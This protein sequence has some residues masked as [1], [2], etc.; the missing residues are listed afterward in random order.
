[1][2]LPLHFNPRPY[3]VEAL[4]AL[5]S[6]VAMCVLCWARRAGKDMT[7]FAYASKKMVEEPMNVVLV[8]PE[9][10]QGKTA[11]WENVEN[12]GWKTIDRIP[13]SLVARVDNSDMRITL[14]NGST[15]Q[16]LGAGDPEALRGANGKIY[17]FS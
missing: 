8:F 15:F 3:Q 16:V 10:Q 11:F 9:K 2:Q 13:K 7:S 12:D 5:E 4:N 6:G 17:I 14:T 1:M